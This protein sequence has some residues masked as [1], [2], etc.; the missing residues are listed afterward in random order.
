MRGDGLLFVSQQIS[1]ESRSIFRKEATVHAGMHVFQQFSINKTF[2]DALIAGRQIVVG[3]HCYDS[4]G[5]R[6]L[7]L[8]DGTICIN[9]WQQ[10]GKQTIDRLFLDK[11]FKDPLSTSISEY[12]RMEDK[13]YDVFVR[14]ALSAWNDRPRVEEHTRTMLTIDYGHGKRFE[15]VEGYHMV[16]S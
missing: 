12:R 1:E 13:A 11:Y 15:R 5:L 7:K 10:Q 9:P 16:S 14:N 3:R 2:R 4:G 6:I 8:V